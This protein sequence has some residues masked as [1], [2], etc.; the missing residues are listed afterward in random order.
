M[1]PT[2]VVKAKGKDATVDVPVGTVAYVVATGVNKIQLDNQGHPQGSS[3][4]SLPSPTFNMLPTEHAQALPRVRL[5]IR[6]GLQ[7]DAPR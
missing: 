3:S 4:V 7:V 5:G 6:M 2:Q 1:T